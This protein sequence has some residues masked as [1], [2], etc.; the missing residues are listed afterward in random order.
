MC[1]LTCHLTP[2]YSRQHNS[3]AKTLFDSVEE[4]LE[5]LEDNVLLDDCHAAVLAELG[6]FQEAADI[7]MEEGRPLEAIKVLLEDKGNSESTTRANTYIL[8]GLWQNTSFSHKIKDTDTDS[9]ELLALASQVDTSLLSP[10][11]RDEVRIL[12][13]IYYTHR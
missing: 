6:R 7:H 10:S 9:I 8:R 5:Y 3:K 1:H 2:R 11:Q 4:Q 12:L 13:L